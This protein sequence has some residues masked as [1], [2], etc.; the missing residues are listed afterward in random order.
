MRLFLDFY[1]RLF[2]VTITALQSPMV[3]S[4]NFKRRDN[5]EIELVFAKGTQQFALPDGTTGQLGIKRLNDYDG[6]FLALSNSWTITGTAPLPVYVFRLNLNT[7]EINTIFEESADTIDAISAMMEI[8]WTTPDG[9]VST[10]STLPAKIAN[11]VVAGDEGEPVQLPAFYASETSD[12][13]ATQLQAINGTNNT[14]WMTPLRT[15]QAIAALGGAGG[16]SGGGVTS[17]ND[18]SDIPASFPP[19]THGHGMSDIAGLEAALGGKQAAGSY[20]PA[21][22]IAP[23]AISG[24]AV[25]TTDARLSD[26]RQPTSHIHAAADITTG[27]LDLAR[28][29]TGTTGSTVALGNHTHPG[30]VTGTGGI[31]TIARVSSMPANPDA[32]TLYIVLP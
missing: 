21:T 31:A 25:I 6:P 15:A 23:S 14:A 19:A 11:D 29:P 7:V 20:A 26:S 28:V 4:V 13:K 9:V 8:T 3:S 30:M 10:S 27:T 5:D 17:Y 1:T 12:L 2:P 18:L 32:N 22:G 16:G 24:T